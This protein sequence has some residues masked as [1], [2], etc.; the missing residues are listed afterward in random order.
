MTKP[1]MHPLL[2]PCSL[3]CWLA[4]AGSLSAQDQSSALWGRAGERWTPQS[5]LPD[6]SYAGYH[7]GE[8]PLPTLKPTV[9]VKAFGAVGDGIADDTLAIQKAIDASPG[10]V[11]HLP[12][13]RYKITNFLTIRHGGTVLQ[14]AGPEQSV[15]FCPIPLNTIKPN[16]GA[17]TTGQ[18]TSNYSWSGGFIQVTGPSSTKFLAS[19]TAPAKRGDHTLAVSASEPFKVGDDVALRLSDTSDKSLA[20]HLY[21]GDPGPLDQLGV[22]RETFRCRV[23]KIDPVAGR[24][25]FDRPLLT[26]VRLEWKPGLFAAARSVEEV[27]LEELG[28]EFPNTPYLGHFTELGYNAVS[29]GDARN[30]W[31]RHLRIHNSDSGLFVGGVNVTVQGVLLTSERPVEKSRQAT[32][33]HGITLSGQDNLLRD[34]E[35]RTRFMHDITMTRGSAG[36]VVAAGRGLDLALDHHKYAPHHNLFTDLDLGQGSRM[37]QSGGGDKLGRHSA[38]GETFWNVRARQPQTWPQG[39]GPDLMNLVGVQSNGQS[40][41]NL[42]GPWFEAIAPSRLEPANLYQAQLARRLAKP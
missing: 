8:A 17:T 42:D 32:G 6:F 22:I 24:I 41:T 35:F 10:K 12:P 34:F 11:I 33:H 19:V 38:A 28:F 7:R 37:F 25:E 16:W 4:L 26:D 18:R 39:W 9:D 23:T 14:G 13:G 31:L 40:L 2:S 3:C 15:F 1:H 36:N 20:T 5:R 29:I 21:A 27:G 30:C